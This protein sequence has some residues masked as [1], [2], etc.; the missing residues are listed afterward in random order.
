MKNKKV[1]LV[2]LE[3]PYNGD[4]EK[5]IKYARA[6]M[7]DCFERGEFPFASHLLYTQEG[8]I[9]DKLRGEHEPAVKKGFVYEEPPEGREL[10]IQA[11]FEW[12]KF[13]DAT[14]VYT[15]LG[16]TKGMKQGIKE[17]KKQGRTIEYRTL[18]NYEK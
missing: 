4:V 12:G 13:A 14:V 10:G 1:R 2:V 17:A 9:H 11:G 7:K 18:N 6:C 15:N 5:N 16:I 3:S 8:I